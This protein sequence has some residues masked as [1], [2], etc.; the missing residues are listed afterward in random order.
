MSRKNKDKNKEILSSENTE[1]NIDDNMQL[2]KGF[3]F[4]RI[5]DINMIRIF[6]VV[7]LAA[8]VVAAIPFFRPTYSNAEKRELKKFPKFSFKSLA[9]GDYFDD[10]GLWFSDTFPFR[11]TLVSINTTVT[12]AFGIN[13]VQVHGKV[14]QGDD[15][16]DVSADNSENSASSVTE[17]PPE[18]DTVSTVEPQPET[19]PESQPETP[20]VASSQPEVSV[21]E[22]ASEQLGAML[23]VDNAAYEYYN[24]VQSTADNYITAVNRAAE[25]LSGK[26]NVYSMV[27]PTS[28]AITLPE[29]YSGSTN[30]S[31]QQKAINYIYSKMSPNVSTVNVYDTLINHKNEYLYFRTDHHWTALGAYYAYR[32]LMTVKG[33]VPAELTA[34]TEYRFEG[35]LGSFYSESG[36]KARLGNTPDTVFAY[37]PLQ[38]QYIHTF[39]KNG[40]ADYR[41]VSNGDRLS[42]SNKY[43][44]FIGG[45]QPYGIITNPEITD[46]SSCLVIKESFGNAMVGFLSQNYQNVYVVDYRYISQVFGG[47]LV[48]FVD[49]RGIQ[50]VIFANNISATRNKSLVN[51]INTFVG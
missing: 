16:P 10:I 9:N 7:W 3:R 11:D 38:T 27:I 19:P 5:I 49:E 1:K 24:F 18:S 50:D 42:A 35:F 26:S 46:G 33:A 37:E 17:I 44:A 34:F 45:D 4:Q 15:I 25:Y 51:A 48:Q 36:Q 22:P 14:E 47:N 31:N 32:E 13:K 6:L 21:Q 39:T 40:E 23:I 30:S 28:M 20:P 8:S 29:G 41:I 43:L 12:D 2:I